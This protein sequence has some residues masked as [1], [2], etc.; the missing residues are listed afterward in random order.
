MLHR[1][2]EPHSGNAAGEIP[3]VALAGITAGLVAILA[4]AV[5]MDLLLRQASPRS[6]LPNL[7]G[8]VSA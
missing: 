5:L 7:V 1:S 6:R 2:E 4:L 8:Q 3:D